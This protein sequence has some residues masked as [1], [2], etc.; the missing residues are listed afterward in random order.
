[1]NGFD[2][3]WQTL[4]Q[5][6]NDLRVAVEGLEHNQVFHVQSY[7]EAYDAA[8]KLS[9]ENNEFPRQLYMEL[10]QELD[11]Y[12]GENV[13]S[14][15][16]EAGEGKV[17]LDAIQSCWMNHV[18]MKKWFRNVFS[19]LDR[20]YLA[21]HSMEED[22]DSIDTT[23]IKSFKRKIYDELKQDVTP[24]VISLIN[25]ERL[26]EIVDSTLVKT[27][28]KLYEIVGLS[29]LDIYCD[30]FECSYLD[31][32]RDYY[33]IKLAEWIDQDS[34][35]EYM[36]KVENVLN[37]E[38]KRCMDYLHPSTEE[39]V[40]KLIENEMIKSVIEALLEKEGSGCKVLLQNDK[41]DDLKRMYSLFSRVGD[42]A[43]K[44]MAKIYY[45]YMLSV[46]NDLIQQR[47]DRISAGEKDKDDD[48]DF[49]RSFMEL[50]EKYKAMNTDLFDDHHL[51]QKSMS[52]AFSNLIN[53]N[54][55]NKDKPGKLATM[56]ST[57]VDRMLQ[58]KKE[59]M[60]D[61]E[62]EGTLDKI[63][64]LFTYLVDKD[65]FADV[66]RHQ[67]AKRLLNQRS[68]SE[69]AE[70]NMISR[71]KMCCGTNYTSKM[72]GMMNDLIANSGDISRDILADRGQLDFSVKILTLP[73]WPSYVCPDVTLPPALRTCVES[74]QTSYA[75]KSATRKLSWQYTLGSASIRATFGAKN[76]YD[77]Q[78]STLQAIILN[79]F[80][81][82]SRFTFEQLKENLNLDDIILKPLL[83]SL[84]CGKYKLLAKS[85]SPKKSS[86]INKTDS[87]RAN[88]EFTSKM[89]KIKIAMPNLDS[90][91]NTKKVEQDRSHSI[92]AVIVRIMKSRKTMEHKDLQA[93]VLKQLAFFK[94]NPR[95][96]K[97]RIEVLIEQEY[98]ERSNENNNIY[99][100]LA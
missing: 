24:S 2:E 13:L 92:D 72:E 100:Y 60:S 55:L 44:P 28:I 76:I 83:H 99:N 95:A 85:P 50:H 51:F 39:K 91:H 14:S 58:S 30:D 15:I 74:F 23:A 88:H 22:I 32:T 63:V 97:K 9:T 56:I 38:K 64:H 84:S 80:N 68:V 29:S 1:M 89:R 59:K 53:D 57:F 46:G 87:F 12:L 75:N 25:S 26:G 54:L 82:G 37:V 10:C 69:E 70:K 65:M 34:T 7:I 42:D 73:H 31:S 33:V 18:I 48:P 78:L 8:Y 21:Q 94:P 27:I 67:L 98:L 3:R 35:P 49:I 81:D 77:V 45:E 90:T 20:Y 61:V 93:N 47:I 43:L 71:F 41:A 17:L 79:A 86:K 52:N 19:T 4:H 66:Y 16:L 40:S 36:I 11:Q 6:I 62:L 96:I 5:S